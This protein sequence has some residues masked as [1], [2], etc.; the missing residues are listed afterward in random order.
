M[1]CAMESH[2]PMLVA[3][4]WMGLRVTMYRSFKSTFTSTRLCT[5]TINVA[6]G[7]AHEYKVARPKRMNTSDCSLII[8]ASDRSD[9]TWFSSTKSTRS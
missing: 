9:I 5:N 4:C 6:M 8:Y 1:K 2:G 7:H 3:I